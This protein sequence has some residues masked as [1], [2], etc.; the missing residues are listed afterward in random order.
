VKRTAPTAALA[1]AAL[2]FGTTFIV[3]KDAVEA[4]GVVPFLSARFLV[5]AATLAPLARR[6]PRTPGVV[7]A[8]ALAGVALAGG[9]LFQTFGLRSVSSS[10]SAFITYLL[11]VFVPVLSA[12]LLRRPP[13]TTT[14]FAVVLATTGLVLMTGGV[15]SVGAGELLTLACAVL[16]A[17]HIVLLADYAPRHDTVTLNLVQ[18]VVVGAALAGPG[19]LG[20]GYDFPL[21]VWLAIAYTGVVVTAAA[22]MLQV[23]GQRSIGP[24]RTALVLLLEPV[25]AGLLG[26]LAGERLGAR[27][28]AGA[29]LI[30]VAILVSE[31]GPAVRAGRARQSRPE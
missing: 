18:L 17:V 24:A 30:L 7:R 23:W 21:R 15:V 8:G 20:G 2:L 11:V 16:F 1:A 22:F 14:V 19:L 31:V 28:L 26:Y 9:Y 6:R 5:G 3:V 25:F 27:G 12:A 13:R 29:A 4:V 10:V